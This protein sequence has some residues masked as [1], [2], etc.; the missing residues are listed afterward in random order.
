MRPGAFPRSHFPLSRESPRAGPRARQCARAALPSTAGGGGAAGWGPGGGA[1]RC[2]QAA[3][4]PARRRAP[5]VSA[6]PRSRRLGEGP[7]RRPP[8]PARGLQEGGLSLGPE[9]R[10]FLRTPKALVTPGRD[11][12]PNPGSPEA[13]V[14]GLG[15]PKA[16]GC[17]LV[18]APKERKSR[19]SPGPL[20]KCQVRGQQPWSLDAKNLV[21]SST[22]D[23][24][25][26]MGRG[27]SSPAKRRIGILRIRPLRWTIECSP[28]SR[29]LRSGQR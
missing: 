9:P 10:S 7:P 3:P 4:R 14:P 17:R 8:G 22:P 5:G 12:A 2:P 20:W 15:W 18:H 11:S 23:S 27:K 1:R 24:Y 13:R 29:A 6:A 19:V 21:G 16:V 25:S 28:R 26:E